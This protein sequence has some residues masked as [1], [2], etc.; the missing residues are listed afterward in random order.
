M[1]F[2][3]P[4][5]ILIAGPTQC[6]KTQLVKR[7]LKEKNFTPY[8]DRIVWAYGE[9]QPTYEIIREE[10]PQIEFVR[11]L[12][13]EVF[14]SF[15]PHRTNL[16]ILDDLMAELGSSPKLSSLFTKGS[17]HRN[18][19]VIYIVQNIYDSGK[20]H[21]TCSLNSHYLVVFKNPRDM[22]QIDSLGRQIVP[23]KKFRLSE[24]VDHAAQVPHGYL[25]VDLRQDTPSIYKFRTFIFPKEHQRL[26][27]PC[28]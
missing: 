19:S 14:E 27:I 3:H 23:R 9:W 28:D 17:H 11:G 15:N 22:S 18:L 2:V 10:N 25:L 6:G 26:Y 21:R 24:V 7:I 16:L 8:P 1:A 5:T 20:S 13:E 12:D 4:C